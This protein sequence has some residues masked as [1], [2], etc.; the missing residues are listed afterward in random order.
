LESKGDKGYILRIPAD[1]VQTFLDG[2]SKIL[3]EQENQE[4]RTIGETISAWTLSQDIEIKVYAEKDSLSEVDLS[5]SAGG[6]TYQAVLALEEEDESS[7]A[8][9]TISGNV[10]DVPMS[11][12]IERTDSRGDKYETATDITVLADGEQTVHTEWSETVVPESAVYKLKGS[13][14]QMGQD[15]FTIEA[16][17]TIKDLKQGV[18][19]SY[20]LD[21]VRILENSSELVSM[22]MELRVSSRESSLE[23]PQGETIE[24]TTDTTDE[25]M[26]QYTEEMQS[27]LGEILSRMN[28]TSAVF[29]GAFLMGGL[30]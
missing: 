9:L 4:I 3:S 18:C 6:E 25:E 26:E 7:S 15:T 1:S 2:F 20:I 27:K 21:D 13:V 19:A 23:P 28:L 8:A 10:S 16:N 5:L 12:T 22:A 24:L 17:G 11:L 29:S 30:S 14:T